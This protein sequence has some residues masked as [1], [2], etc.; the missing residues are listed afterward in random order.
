MPEMFIQMEHQWTET[1]TE[2][3]PSSLASF[4]GSQTFR[5]GNEAIPIPDDAYH[6]DYIENVHAGLSTRRRG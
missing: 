4:L 3:S 6:T 1:S 5:T 2:E